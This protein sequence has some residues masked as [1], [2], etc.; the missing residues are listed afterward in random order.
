[1]AKRPRKRAAKTA[2]RPRKVNQV[3]LNRMIELRK[4]GFSCQEIAQKVERSERTV[5]R[6]TRGIRP[7]VAVVTKAK[8][9]DV[10]AACGKI[11]LYGRDQLELT[12]Q[13]VDFLF[14]KVRKIFESRDPVT[15]E[16]L[17]ADS[18]ARMDFLFNEVLPPAM[19]E[20]KIRRWIERFREQVGDSGMT[21]EEVRDESGQ[22]ADRL[23]PQ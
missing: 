16:W 1:M 22:S 12:T 10:L 11:I 20:I 3:L 4:Q 5:R 2:G 19:G 14:K 17:A 18:K 13:E 8:P 9:V 15:R 23:L 6:Y 21:D 7:Q